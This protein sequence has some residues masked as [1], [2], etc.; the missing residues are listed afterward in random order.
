[1]SIQA[2]IQAAL[3]GLTW[4]TWPDAAPQGAPIPLTI[5]RR[6]DVEPLMT[7]SGLYMGLSKSTFIFECWAKSKKQTL[8]MVDEVVTT[9]EAS[10]LT[11]FREPASGE[12]YEPTTDE[13][14]SPAT[15]S[16]WHP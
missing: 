15:F 8:D 13:V 14:M 7:V 4:K 2:D 11:C 5:F 6:T 16:F 9:I 1:M 10:G 3:A 12:D